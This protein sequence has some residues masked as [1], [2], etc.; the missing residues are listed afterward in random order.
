[1]KENKGFWRMIKSSWI[2]G[3]ALLISGCSSHQLIEHKTDQYTLRND[4]GMEVM[5]ASYGARI[6]AI[7][8]PDREGQFADV[9]LG[10]D[11]IESYKTAHKKPYFGSVLGRYAGRISG[12]TF[13]LDG[14]Q[15]SLN[16]NNGPNHLHGGALGFDKQEWDAAPVENGIRFSKTSPHGEENYP[17][18]LQVSVTYT[19]TKTNEL[20]ID[21]S[22]TT[23]RACPVNLSNHAYFNLA[24]EGAPT[25]LNH[26]L[27]IAAENILELDP[28][29]VPTGKKLQVAGTPFD[30]RKAKP[31]GRDIK[32][33]HGQLKIGNGYDHTF[34]LNQQETA[35]ELYDPESGRRMEVITTEPSI[36]LYTANFLDG[37]LK[38]KSGR[39][40]E[41]RSA[42][43][44][45][46]QHFPDS[47]N[48]PDFPNTILRPGEEYASQTIYRFST[49]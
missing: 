7:K 34:V 29:S 44:L 45:E 41:Q 8:V 27:T 20:I 2:V 6:T 30:F 46:T 12:A 3:F 33:D 36:Q 4:N 18:A 43:C 24:G 1:V 5:L 32:S 35:A 39:P 48:Q 23:D 25:V 49:R 31:V 21:Y 28:T 47:P 26:E 42:L 15:H 11:D 40:Y 10:Y 13:T 16:A 22:A 14:V 9:V 38:G 17:G 37:S 19:L